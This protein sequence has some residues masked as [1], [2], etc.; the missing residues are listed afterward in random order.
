[1]GNSRPPLPHDTQTVDLHNPSTAQFSC[2]NI[3]S[4][5]L[6][7]ICS[8]EKPKVTLQ[9]VQTAAATLLTANQQAASHEDLVLSFWNYFSCICLMYIFIHCLHIFNFIFHYTSF[10][11]STFV[12]L[13]YFIS[14]TS[15]FALFLNVDVCYLMQILIVLLLYVN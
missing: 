4:T 12:I 1:M 2:F 9:L 7:Q 14:L 11:L 13:T 3:L 10:T 15:L 5:G 8:L 6:L